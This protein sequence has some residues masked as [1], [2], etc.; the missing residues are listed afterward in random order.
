MKVF[1]FV[2]YVCVCVCVTLVHLIVYYKGLFFF[3]IL[4]PQRN[5]NLV[6]VSFPPKKK[7]GVSILVLAF[8][9]QTWF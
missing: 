5:R 3:T 1:I 6:L 8:E 4:V 2:G 7:K 9:N